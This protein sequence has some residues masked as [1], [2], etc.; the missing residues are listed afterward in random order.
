MK[1]KQLL[2]VEGKQSAEKE[3]RFLIDVKRP[4]IIRLIQAAREQ[5]D[6]SEN[7]DYDAAKNTQAE[8]EGRIKELTSLLDNAKLIDENKDANSVGVGALVL[9]FDH[10]DKTEQSYRILGKFEADSSKV[11][12]LNE[13]MTI[14]ISNE[15]PLAKALF[16]HKVGDTVEVTG[17]DHPYHVTIKKITWVK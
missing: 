7:A 3:L 15:S 2:S 1:K 8:I 13:G 16:D 4:E 10:S 6:L 12:S 14:V 5:G 17:I 9:V 11:V